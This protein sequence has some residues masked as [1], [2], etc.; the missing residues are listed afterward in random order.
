M[1]K[2]HV[3]FVCAIACMFLVFT[4]CKQSTHPEEAVAT[5]QEEEDEGYDGP[6]ERAALDFEKVKDPKL[7]Y[8]P[9]DRLSFA[10]EAAMSSKQANRTDALLWVE[11][12]P[13]Y[14]SV[15]PSNGNTRAGN[16]YTAGRIRGVLVDAAD[17]SGNTVLAGGVAGGLW[18]CTNFLSAVPNW[19]AANDFFDNLAV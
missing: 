19:Q 6:A 12:G 2:F 8:A 3:L 17:P 5:E 7:G 18:R 14:D 11:R 15:G 16:G 13:I 10:I 1:R 9:T 4:S